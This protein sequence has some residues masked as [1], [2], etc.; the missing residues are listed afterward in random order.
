MPKLARYVLVLAIAAFCAATWGLLMREHLIV[1]HTVNIDANY[2]GLLDPEQDDRTATWGLYL[3][4]TR[5]GMA[6]THYTR[7]PDGTIWARADTSVSRKVTQ[8]LGLEDDIELNFTAQVSPLRG[9]L[10]FSLA[11]DAVDLLVQGK[12]EGSQILLNGHLGEE[13]IT[14]T[15]P[16]Q[17]RALTGTVFSP[18]AAAPR[19][20]ERNIGDLWMVDLLNPLTA[21][22]QSVSIALRE[23]TRIT[24]EDVPETVYKLGFAMGNSSWYAWVRENGEPLVQGTPF[25]VHLRRT[26][27]PQEPLMRL[28]L[29]PRP[30]DE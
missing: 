12:V 18:M 5:V 3:G 22:P 10:A 23:K 14:E 30:L 27:M 15:V 16:Y 29:G 2:D 26:D 7:Q 4:Q 20:A 28:K 13:Q 17:G 25:P 24:L 1:K 9:L 21:L 11:C 19:L 8:F 6:T